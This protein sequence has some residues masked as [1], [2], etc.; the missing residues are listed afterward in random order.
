ENVINNIINITTQKTNQN[1]YIPIHP[2]FE[3]VLTKRNGEFPRQIADQKFNKY[4]KTICEKVDIKEQV[5]GAKINPKTNRKEF[6]IYPKHELVTS[7]IC[8]RSFAT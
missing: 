2:Q 3:E 5:Y 6:N 1:L 4:I 7:H 8:R